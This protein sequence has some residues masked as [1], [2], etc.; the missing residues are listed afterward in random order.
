[1]D[2]LLDVGRVGAPVDDLLLDGPLRGDSVNA[3]IC[4]RCAGAAGLA[5]RN[6]AT[7]LPSK[8]ARVVCLF[9]FL[10]SS[11]NHSLKLE[12]R[13]PRFRGLFS[14]SLGLESSSVVEAAVEALLWVSCDVVDDMSR[15]SSAL[16]TGGLEGEW[17]YSW[18]SSLGR[19]LDMEAGGGDQ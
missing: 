4:L 11:L 17:L 3:L 15:L 10:R 16:S 8:P 2:D 12:N 13:L 19:G 18:E 6:F 7:L 9:R 5:T 14:P 1:M